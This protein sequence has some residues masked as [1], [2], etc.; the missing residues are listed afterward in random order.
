[1]QLYVDGCL[2]ISEHTDV[3][4][5]RLGKYF[6]LNQGSFGSQNIH[7]GG[8]L[9]QVQLMNGVSARA[10]SVVQYIQDT[11]NNVENVLR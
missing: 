7:L 8:K 1:M 11:V 6:I 2:Y 9:S 4:L 10:I 5:Y 3:V